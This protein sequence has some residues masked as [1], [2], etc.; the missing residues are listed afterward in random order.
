MPPFYSLFLSS[1]LSASDLNPF[2]KPLIVPHPLASSSLFL[3]LLTTSTHRPSKQSDASETHVI[4]SPSGSV[5][6]IALPAAS[7]STWNTPPGL[8][9][10]LFLA[11]VSALV[12]LWKAL[13]HLVYLLFI[14]SPSL[15]VSSWARLFTDHWVNWGVWLACFPQENKPRENYHSVLVSPPSSQHI[16][17]SLQRRKIPLDYY[18]PP[19][20][21]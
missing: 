21:E 7:R 2:S 18:I 6:S 10:R 9:T 14:L 17:K 13:L 19:N 15:H 20:L 11:I 8:H 3:T 16:L 12:S 5:F 4:R 1:I